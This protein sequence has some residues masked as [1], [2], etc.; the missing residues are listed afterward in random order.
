MIVKELQFKMVNK[1]KV[2]FMNFDIKYPNIAAWVRQGSIEIGY[3]YSGYENTFLRVLDEGG[4]VWQ[5]SKQFDSLDSALTEMDAGIAAWRA[6][7]GVQL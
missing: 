4:L 7:Q 1:E 3:T 2:L 6:E 5:S